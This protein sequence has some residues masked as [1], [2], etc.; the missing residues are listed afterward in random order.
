MFVLVFRL[1]HQLETFQTR[2]IALVYLTMI[3][4]LF[5]THKDSHRLEGFIT[6]G[7]SHLTK[8]VNGSNQF[9]AEV[10]GV[11]TVHEP[12]IEKH[13]H[14]RTI[15]KGSLLLNTLEK[16][17]S[18]QIAAHVVIQ[19]ALSKVYSPN[20]LCLTLTYGIENSLS[21][22]GT[23]DIIDIGFRNGQQGIG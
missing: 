7:H 19:V 16:G 6:F 20:G 9:V 10:K 5:T 2:G 15:T 3:M 22:I 13:L 11:V 21:R 23:G 14:I 18:L 4:V 8:G 1:T 12:L 17:E